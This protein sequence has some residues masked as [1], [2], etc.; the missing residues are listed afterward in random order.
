MPS[1]QEGRD[2]LAQLFV[3]NDG[4][5]TARLRLS[6]AEAA[7][8]C[9]VTP[10]Q[11]TYWAKKGHVKPST[12]NGHD[13]DLYA[14]EKVIRIRQA[15]EKGHSLEK[16]AQLVEQELAGLA[17]EAER[18]AAL[19]AGDLEEEL[20][21]RLEGLEER[22]EQLRRSVGS[23]LTIARLR[24]A[25]VTL[26]RLENEGTLHAATVGPGEDARA[27]VLRLGRAVDELESLLREVRP[28]AV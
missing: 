27:I 3:A 13:Y 21:R 19:A 15:L 12:E 2:L 28:A 7:R 25:V 8:V 23:T 11:L 26:A 24:K 1:D 10:R 9:S 16:A 22:V 18:L 6:A 20:K 5:V 17:S 14:M 4:E